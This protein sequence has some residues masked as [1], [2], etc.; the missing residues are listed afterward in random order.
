[1]NKKLV[2]KAAADVAKMKVQ[3]GLT[4]EQKSVDRTRD[5]NRCN[6]RTS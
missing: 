6:K 3:T 4:P 2:G 1:M 5:N